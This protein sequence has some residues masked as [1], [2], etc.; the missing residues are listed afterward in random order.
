MQDMFEQYIQESVG[1]VVVYSIEDKATF[2]RAVEIL[3]SIET[4]KKNKFKAILIGNNIDKQ[5][6]NVTPNE[7]SRLASKHNIKFFE[8]SCATGENVQ[9]AFQNLRNQRLT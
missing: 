1:F 2:D 6:R 3:E 4:I 5:R 7:G 9:Q 8:T